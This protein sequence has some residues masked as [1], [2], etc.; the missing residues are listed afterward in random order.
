MRF[1]IGNPSDK[2]FVDAEDPKAAAAAITLLGHG[3]YFCKAE[4]GTDYPAFYVLG[5]DPQEIWKDK[6]GLTLNEYLA[7]SGLDAI[8][9][10]LKTFRYDGERSSMNNIGAA[11]KSWIKN[12]EKHKA[13]RQAQT[14]QPATG[15]SLPCDN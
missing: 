2:C 7:G 13:E 6:F 1:E 4:D 9:D 3:Q 10:C 5:G 14:E 8:I 11:A 12:L 15:R